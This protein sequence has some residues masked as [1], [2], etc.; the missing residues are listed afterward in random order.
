MID[1]QDCTSLTQAEAERIDGQKVAKVVAREFE[2]ELTF[3][4]GACLL[5]KGNCFGGALDSRVD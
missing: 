3:E 1:L 2:L 5:V 4:N